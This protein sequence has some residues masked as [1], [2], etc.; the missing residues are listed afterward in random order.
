MNE[1][2]D[3]RREA[4]SA[5]WCL[6][7]QDAKAF[8]FPEAMIKEM[9]WRYDAEF[10]EEEDGY[11]EEEDRFKLFESHLAMMEFVLQDAAPDGDT[12][13]PNSWR[14]AERRWR[15]HHGIDRLISEEEI[16]NTV[17]STSSGRS[18]KAWDYKLEGK[19]Y[20]FHEHLYMKDST[21]IKERE[22]AERA[23]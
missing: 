19:K 17:I 4:I 3:E 21:W 10:E 11:R 14:I 6:I 23:E 12:E 8:K 9:F 16:A 5:Q 1:M 13:V 18:A 15:I 22:E 20:V 2:S 7:E